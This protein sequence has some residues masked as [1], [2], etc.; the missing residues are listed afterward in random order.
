MLDV[1]YLLTSSMV[2]ASTEGKWLSIVLFSANLLL[3]LLDV[4]CF[5]LY[6][7]PKS[8]EAEESEDEG[9][10]FHPFRPQPVKLGLSEDTC[11]ICLSDFED[12]DA[13]AMKLPCGHLFHAECITRWLQQSRHCPMRCPELVLPP[14]ETPTPEAREREQ[15]L[16]VAVLPGQIPSE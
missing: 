9:E 5:L 10:E 3:A 16:L 12:Q 2:T 1:M 15:V 4:I 14:Q 13:E 8:H 6:A 7:L 11:V